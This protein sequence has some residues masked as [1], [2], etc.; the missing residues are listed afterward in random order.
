VVQ[1]RHVLLIA[2]RVKLGNMEGELIRLPWVPMTIVVGFF[3]FAFFPGWLTPFGPNAMTLTHR[4]QPPGW[5]VE[6]RKYLLGTDTLGRD[7]L[8][9]IF[10]GARISLIIAGFGLV[11]GGGLGLAIGIVSGYMGGKFDVVLMRLTDVFMA[12]PTLLIALVF[13]MTVGSGLQTVIIAI[14]IIS[15]SRFAR[16]IRSEVLSLKEREFVLLA[17][18][19]G[20]SSLRIMLV[21]ILPNVLNTFMVICSLQVSQCILTEATLSFLGAGISPPTPTWG[22][23]V[24]DGRDYLTSAWWIGLFPGLAL[25]S[26]VFAFN[27]LGDWLRDRLDPR[28]R[29]V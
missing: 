14:S 25:T 6:G 13:V 10:Y 3:L 28:L 19:A 27:T 5:E 16:I 20:C 12:L 1:G 2:A 17:K 11:F 7:V 15:W 18:V 24:S 29:Q 26:V 23:M 9:R 21:H 4:L 22:N 8:T